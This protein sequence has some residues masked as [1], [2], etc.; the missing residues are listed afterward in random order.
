MPRLYLPDTGETIGD[1]SDEQ[2]DFLIDNLE[3][4]SDDDR[5]YYINQDTLD[6]FQEQGG[7][8]ALIALLRRALGD[9]EDIDIAWE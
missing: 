3:E 1:I 5:D 7:D 2:L 8:P 9:R 6:M 4:E